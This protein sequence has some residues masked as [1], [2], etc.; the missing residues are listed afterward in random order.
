MKMTK[1]VQTQLSNIEEQPRPTVSQS[2]QLWE[3]AAL[4]IQASEGSKSQ[5]VNYVMEVVYVI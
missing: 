1:E 3:A 2:C 4:V 5:T